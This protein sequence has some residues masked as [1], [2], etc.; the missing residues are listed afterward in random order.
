MSSELNELSV[1]QVAVPTTLMNVSHALFSS[2]VTEVDGCNPRYRVDGGLLMLNGHLR[3]THLKTV[4]LSCLK[5][6]SPREPACPID[7][8]LLQ[9]LNNTPQPSNAS[10][11]TFLDLGHATQSDLG[12]VLQIAPQACPLSYL[13]PCCQPHEQSDEC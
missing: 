11:L 9:Y 2:F 1:V 7:S 8:L 6:S 10:A 3:S 12:L 13:Q 4:L 5:P